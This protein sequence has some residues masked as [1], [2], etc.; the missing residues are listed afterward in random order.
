MAMGGNIIE[1]FAN[2]DMVGNDLRFF[3]S[4]GSP[5]IR[6]AGMTISGQ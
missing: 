1:M 6:I 3:G 2:I 5:T 4:K